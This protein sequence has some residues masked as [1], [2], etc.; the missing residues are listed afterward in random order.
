MLGELPIDET[1]RVSFRYARR[2]AFAGVLG[3]GLR[4]DLSSAWALRVDAR[5]LLGP[6]T[7]RVF[8]DAQ[9]SS[10]RGVPA[11]FIES[12][13]N[14]GPPPAEWP[15]KTPGIRS[16]L[17]WCMTGVTRFQDLDCH[18]LAVQIRREVLRL[19]RRDDVRRDFKFVS[20]IRGSARSA[21]RNIAE[22]YSRFNPTEILQ[23][24]SYAKASLDETRN[25]MTDGEESRYFSTPE[26]EAV[27]TPI[28][29]TLGA[30]LR[31]MHYL[32]SPKARQFYARYRARRRAT[33]FESKRRPE[34]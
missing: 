10:V 33:P 12:F 30:I 18:K 29:R 17:R 19:T 24:L 7:T 14:P 16:A 28:A 22:G 34:P 4:R 31:W 23:F 3:G 5:V 20:P 9:P 2:A 11:G 25:H 27:Q 8:L 21:P 26:T 13:T 1:D 15:I 32:E 6:D